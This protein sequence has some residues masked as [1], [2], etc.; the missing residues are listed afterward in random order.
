LENK[1]GGDFVRQHPH[2]QPLA[3][4]RPDHLICPVCSSG[5]RQQHQE[6]NS[7]IICGSC[8]CALE[9]DLLKT[10]EQIVVLPDAL[11][12][13]PLG[14]LSLLVEGLFMGLYMAVIRLSQNN[15]SKESQL[16]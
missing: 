7:L 9:S 1:K 6:L 12:L 11:G 4:S 13:E 8:G 16:S 10:L 2:I 15:V 14:I 3:A 5:Q